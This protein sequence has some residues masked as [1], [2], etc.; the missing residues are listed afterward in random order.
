MLRRALCQLDHPRA[1]PRSGGRLEVRAGRLVA[2]LMGVGVGA[3]RTHLLLTFAADDI[4]GPPLPDRGLQLRRLQNGLPQQHRQ[5]VEG[6]AAVRAVCAQYGRHCRGQ[7][8]RQ[9]V[10]RHD[11]PCACQ[12]HSHS[13]GPPASSSCSMRLHNPRNAGEGQARDLLLWPALLRQHCEADG[14]RAA[15]VRRCLFPVPEAQMEATPPACWL[16]SVNSQRLG[17]SWAGAAGVPHSPSPLPPL[18]QLPPHDNLP[19]VRLPASRLPD[20]RRPDAAC[21][22]G[23]LLREK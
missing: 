23:G 17:W 21:N 4:S 16:R 18:P 22:A 14:R 7:C 13:L 19:A 9:T 1:A 2:G 8:G 15:R 5:P 12:L 6:Y 20:G 11:S 3:W 10:A